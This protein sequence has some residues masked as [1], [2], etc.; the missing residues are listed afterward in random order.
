MKQKREGRTAMQ[1]GDRLL[2]KKE[3]SKKVYIVAKVDVPHSTEKAFV[4]KSGGDFTIGIKVWKS[5]YVW[6]PKSQM[7]VPKR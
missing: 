1:I 4:S 7:W 5:D 3:S 2:I 6:S